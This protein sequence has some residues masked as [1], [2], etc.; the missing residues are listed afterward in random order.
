MSLSLSF[1]VLLNGVTANKVSET[2][3]HESIKDA[4]AS[5]DKLSDLAVQINEIKRFAGNSEAPA[6]SDRIEALACH[7]NNLINKMRVSQCRALA[8]FQSSLSV[9]SVFML[10]THTYTIM[11]VYSLFLSELEPIHH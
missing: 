1:R 11:L 3:F 5:Y 8:C 7:S 4:N 9:C 2:E 10:N 6:A